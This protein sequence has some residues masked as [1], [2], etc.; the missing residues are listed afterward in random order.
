MVGGPSRAP[1]HGGDHVGALSV[2]ANAILLPVAKAKGSFIDARDIAAVA[3]VILEYF[4]LGYSERMTDSVQ[5]IAGQVPRS[6]A[7]YAQDYKAEF[8]VPTAAS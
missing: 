7:Q 5:T 3:S 4:R 1:G 8:A 2:Q 6:F